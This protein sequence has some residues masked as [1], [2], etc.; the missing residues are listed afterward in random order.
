MASAPLGLIGTPFW[1]VREAVQKE[2]VRW[3]LRPWRSDMT[4]QIRW[5]VYE[6]GRLY[7]S[8][9]DPA[10]AQEVRARGIALDVLIEARMPNQVHGTYVSSKKLSAERISGGVSVEMSIRDAVIGAWE[11]RIMQKLL[12]PDA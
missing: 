1:D 6:N 8:W 9:P 10:Y 7:G 4:S 11:E 3:T 2:R 12:G 5:A